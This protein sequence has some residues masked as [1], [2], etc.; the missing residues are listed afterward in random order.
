MNTT[1]TNGLLLA[2]FGACFGSFMAGLGYCVRKVLNHDGKLL[3]LETQIAAIQAN[4][5]RHQKWGEELTAAI[6]RID[7]NSIRIASKLNVEIY[8]GP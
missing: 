6:T 5:V 8:D 3:E 1:L 2:C 7:K 4:C